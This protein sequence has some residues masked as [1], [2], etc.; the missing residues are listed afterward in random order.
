MAE[1]VTGS[2]LLRCTKGRSNKE[3][4]AEIYEDDTGIRFYRGRYGPTGRINSSKE[5][6]SYDFEGYAKLVNEKINVKFYTIATVNGKP[7]LSQD[8]NEALLMASGSLVFDRTSTAQPVKQI[9]AVDVVV[10]F[11]PGCFAPVW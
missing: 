5:Y 2:I 3:Y 7:F 4:L 8:V 6:G 1:K 9:K 11:D 10:T